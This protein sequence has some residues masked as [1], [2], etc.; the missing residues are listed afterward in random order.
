MQDGK[1]LI[2]VQGLRLYPK[3]FEI[4]HNVGLN[5]LQPCFCGF[6]VLSLHTE[7]NVFR[8]CQAVI[9]ARKLP[10]EHP[11]IFAPDFVKCVLLLRD[12]NGL[13]E[14]LH[15]RPLVNKRKLKTDGRIKVVEEIT[16]VLKNS[17][18]VLILCKL[19]IDIEKLHLLCK[20]MPAHVTDT[21]P[22]HFPVGDCLLCG[23]RD[24]PV[25]L[26]LFHGGDKPLFFL[27]CQLPLR[28][29]P[30]RL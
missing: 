30:D 13:P 10:P 6:Q 14:T 7:G 4:R 12:V 3:H 8:L 1:A 9:A 27:P 16:P 23:L 2:A 26:R 5:P 15:I 24:F 11:G 29:E 25:P 21:V 17:V 28:H 20:V 18:L 22:V 19:V